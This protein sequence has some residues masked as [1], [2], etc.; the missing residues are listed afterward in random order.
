MTPDERQRRTK[1][2]TSEIDYLV[3]VANA[4]S[5]T[6][7]CAGPPACEPESADAATGKREGG[8]CFACEVQEW[9]KEHKLLNRP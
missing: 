2:K 4:L 5:D 9:L 7:G 3:R 6:L 8:L 1:L